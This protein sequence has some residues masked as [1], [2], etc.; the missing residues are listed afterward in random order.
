MHVL[1]AILALAAAPPPPK[2]LGPLALY[3]AARAECGSGKPAPHIAQFLHGYFAQWLEPYAF[4]ARLL[5][6]WGQLTD[7]QRARFAAAADKKLLAPERVRQIA[8]FCDRRDTYQFTRETSDGATRCVHIMIRHHVGGDA[9]QVGWVLAEQPGG[10]WT[11]DR[12]EVPSMDYPGIDDDPIDARVREQLA[13][14]A[15][16]MVALGR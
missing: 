15:R 12:V 10:A 8:A 1:V 9:F 16:A 11:L 13:D 6:D 7:A 3:R 5:S 4:G 14:Y 2:S